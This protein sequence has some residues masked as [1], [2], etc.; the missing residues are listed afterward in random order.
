M[1]LVALTA[2]AARLSQRR[3]LTTFK[4][5]LTRG[6]PAALLAGRHTRYLSAAPY[7]RNEGKA[8]VNPKA[9]P[10][11]SGLQ[12]TQSQWSVYDCSS[13]TPGLGRE[14]EEVL[15]QP[16]GLGQGRQLG[17][18]HWSRRRDQTLSSDPQSAYQEQP[19]PYRHVCY[20][21]I[22]HLR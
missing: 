10:P 20:C 13:L 16:Y 9:A 11:V 21:A 7:L 6:L 5:A 4:P 2:R 18:R 1:R 3:L 22:N 14:L 8:W 17:S 19:L 12:Y 15:H